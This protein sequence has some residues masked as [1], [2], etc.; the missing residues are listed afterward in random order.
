[1]VTAMQN[2]KGSC[3]DIRNHG[4]NASP[5]GL[6]LALNLDDTIRFLKAWHRDPHLQ[7]RVHILQPRIERD[8]TSVMKYP[9]QNHQNSYIQ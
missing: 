3:K 8:R 5:A 9:G 7:L 2:L 6:M 4:S 1:M